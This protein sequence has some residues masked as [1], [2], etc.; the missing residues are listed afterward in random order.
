[1]ISC[2]I[3]IGVIITILLIFPTQNVIT[4]A[5]IVISIIITFLGLA[6]YEEQQEKAEEQIKG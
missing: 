2:G 3:I 5:I 1:M 6:Y 4:I